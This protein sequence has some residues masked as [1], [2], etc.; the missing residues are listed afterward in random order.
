MRILKNQARELLTSTEENKGPERMVCLATPVVGERCRC[1]GI[2]GCG[3]A[4]SW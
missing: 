2:Y 4:F 1:V 3:G